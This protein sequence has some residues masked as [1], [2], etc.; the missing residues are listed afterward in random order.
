MAALSIAGLL[1]VCG[2]VAQVIMVTTKP[3]FTFMMVDYL[4][5]DV[6]FNTIHYF[7]HPVWNHMSAFFYGFITGYLIVKQIRFNISE[8]AATR[9]SLFVLPL[10][11]CAIFA[12]YFWNHYKRPIEKWQMIVYAIVDRLIVLSICAWIAYAA[13]VLS[14][15][16]KK[17]VKTNS[18]T[19]CEKSKNVGTIQS[20]NQLD[21]PRIKLDIPIII[22]SPSDFGSELGGLR[23]GN[24]GLTPSPS[25]QSMKQVLSVAS[26]NDV[27]NDGANLA[28]GKSE[29]SIPS[30]E[31]VMVSSN[32]SFQS[33]S[34]HQSSPNFNKATELYLSSRPVL[35]TA[36]SFGE[37]K[38]INSKK[39][40]SSSPAKNSFSHTDL[41]EQSN[42]TNHS[43]QIDGAKT[44]EHSMKD[45]LVKP[46][47][48]QTRRRQT[49]LC[50]VNILCLMLSRLTFQLY[51]FNMVVL[52]ID[53]THSK[54]TWHF[55]YYFIIMK[56]TAIYIM[57]ALFATVF[58]VVFE[59]PTVA[60]FI[61]WSKSRAAKYMTPK[62]DMTDIQTQ[63]E[64]EV[65]FK[66]EKQI[67]KNSS[68]GTKDL[69]TSDAEVR[70]S[71]FVGL[72]FIADPKKISMNSEQASELKGSRL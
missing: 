9:I 50:N 1:T 6:V 72:S 3:L 26:M 56:S 41:Q 42:M 71:E 22:R 16:P 67:T 28:S 40:S 19:E 29:T 32:T 66:V 70:D 36:L 23:G 47:E 17:Q 48:T 21:Q 20:N 15:K 10:G 51:L 54:Y 13:L 52:W 60:V 46:Q 62:K 4:D 69:N 5:L 12:P 35:K 7:H 38:R 59:S 65:S 49:I 61:L 34:R 43:K 24:L 53:V 11:F 55:S 25:W 2:F 31:Q 8:K 57:S 14:R 68:L 18:Q 58:F 33:L 45:N 27:I 64:K 44:N 37:V 39:Q 30:L 63:N